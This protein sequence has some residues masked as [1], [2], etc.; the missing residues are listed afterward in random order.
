MA[1]NIKELRATLSP[2]TSQNKRASKTRA[3]KD[4]GK[5]NECI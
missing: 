4:E 5:N 3:C 2:E 1:K